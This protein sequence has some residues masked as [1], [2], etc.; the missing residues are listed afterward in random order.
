MSPKITRFFP[1]MILSILLFGGYV[2]RQN[3]KRHVVPT[4][5]IPIDFAFSDVTQR[6]GI[7]F[8]H[9]D[10]L[11]DLNGN[12][13]LLFYGAG[14]A[15]A[16]FNGD[17]WMDIFLPN[18]K[19]KSKS[20][21]YLND[22][23]HSFREVAEE[24]GVGNIAEKAAP[25]APVVFDYDNDGRPDLYVGGLGCALL[26]HNTG[27]RFE[28]MPFDDCS[29]SSGAVPVDTDGDGLLDLYV[30][31][32]WPNFNYF[33]LTSRSVPYPETVDDPLNGGINQLFHNS[34]HGL[35]KSQP[36]KDG[37]D[38]HWSLDASVGRFSPADSRLR[39]Y[40]ANDWGRDLLHVVKDGGLELDTAAGLPFERRSGM[41]VSLGDLDGSGYPHLYVSNIYIPE[42]VMQENF[43]WKLTSDKVV[44][45]ARSYG[46]NAC[47]WAWGGAFADF[48]LDGQQD[49]YV[50]NGF[51]SGQ[52]EK[53]F[54][55]YS[56]VV[57]ALPGTIRNG[58]LGWPSIGN[59]SLSGNQIDCVL[60]KKGKSY[61]NVAKQ[62]GVREAWDGRAVGLIDFDNN[63]AP[64]LLVTVQ[65]GPPHLL[66]N[67]VNPG[68]HWVGFQLIGHKSNR[69]GVGARIEVNQ[70][71]HSY[72]RWD[73]GGRT[74]LMASSEPRLHFGLA[75]TAQVTVKVEWPS[76]IIQRF[77]NIQPGNYY[78]IDEDQGINLSAISKGG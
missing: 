47:G 30:L 27:N 54:S 67:T 3:I 40:T 73:T 46:V 7:N 8:R 9:E 55:F 64:D 76:G 14:V 60:I 78:T 61:V 58:P 32:Y 2:A 42:F 24:W 63:G 39:I 53:D 13:R 11:L 65:D 51:I 16:D 4:S 72:Y 62:A 77:N 44:D 57:M 74:G 18:S 45:E 5:D 43:L 22:H 37:A 23:G 36:G 31:R 29:N 35:E 1:F 38:S 28:Q 20:H 12:T 48:N 75:G 25:A 52:S 15:V 49:L 26:F 21:L 71:D 50:A 69:D 19:P 6:F 68:N 59:R 66:M 10:P 33:K 70:E 56:S 34:G 17:G 41:N